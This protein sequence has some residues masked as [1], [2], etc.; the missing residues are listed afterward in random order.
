M[1]C[2]NDKNRK[3]VGHQSGDDFIICQ[4]ESCIPALKTETIQEFYCRQQKGET[5]EIDNNNKALIIS[6]KRIF[7]FLTVEMGHN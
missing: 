2:F 4:R 1:Q 7:K 6:D 5:S 3:L